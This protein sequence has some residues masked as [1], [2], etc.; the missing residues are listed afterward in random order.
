MVT[1][2]QKDPQCKH[3]LLAS[4]HYPYYK[5]NCT[6]LRRPRPRQHFCSLQVATTLS[7]VRL[8]L[9]NSGDTYGFKEPNNDN[10][11]VFELSSSGVFETD[12]RIRY[13]LNKED[14]IVY[15]MIKN[16]NK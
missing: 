3:T 14:I 7:P 8:K 9:T 11:T 5:G 1:I 2:D 15:L 13:K 12:D 4:T 10:N 16:Y 6:A